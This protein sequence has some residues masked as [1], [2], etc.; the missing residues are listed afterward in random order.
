MVSWK[1][2]P[3]E[4]DLGEKAEH[5]DQISKA[6]V[7]NFFAVPREKVAKNAEVGN[8]GVRIDSS[9]M[10]EIENAYSRI[11]ISS[12]VREAPPAARNLVGGQRKKRRVSVRASSEGRSDFRLNV[13][14]GGLENAVERVLKTYHDENGS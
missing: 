3:S 6:E 10:E 13:G 12:E 2:E 14:S 4:G 11:G 8:N 7:P 9:L 5:L 1:G